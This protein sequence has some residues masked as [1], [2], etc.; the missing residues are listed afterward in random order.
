[1]ILFSSTRIP[2]LID[3]NSQSSEWLKKHLAQGECP[4]EIL[5]QQDP[6]FA[7]QLELAVRFGKTLLI[8]EL[9]FV[10][11]ILIPILRRDLKHQGPRWVVQ[12]GDKQIDYNE[13]FKLYLC[14][15]NACIELQP[16]AKA[17]VSVINFTVTNSGL[18]GQLLSIIINAE[19]PELE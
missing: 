11:P 10:E 15:R 19:Q 14:T 5:N 17:I 1:L 2:L 6:K 16:L 3:P 8:Q 4:V 12:I 7:N 9:D 18:Q 13:T